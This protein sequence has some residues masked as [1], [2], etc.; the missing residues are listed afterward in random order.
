M[1]LWLKEGGARRENGPVVWEWHI[2]T[3]M[4]KTD[5]QEAPTY[6]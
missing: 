6:C 4:F 5:N 3:A 2:H 1:S